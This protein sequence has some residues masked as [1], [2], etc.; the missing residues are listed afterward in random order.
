MTPLGIDALLLNE[1]FHWSTFNAL[2]NMH[3]PI[4]SKEFQIV[5]WKIDYAS[6]E[7]PFTWNDFL[8]WI[9][10]QSLIDAIDI[11]NWIIIQ[12]ILGQ[13]LTFHVIITT[14]STTISSIYDSTNGN[15]LRR[16]KNTALGNVNGLMKLLCVFLWIND[17]HLLLTSSL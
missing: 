3:S 4:V 5:P 13:N 17:V 1:R 8:L 10:E 11:S 7:K 12:M 6:F 14:P 9:L 16:K 15:G 2:G